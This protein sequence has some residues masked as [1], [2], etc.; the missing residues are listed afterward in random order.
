MRTGKLLLLSLLGIASAFAQGNSGSITGTI[1]D[2]AGA[3]VA[4]AAVEGKNNG[5]GSLYATVSTSTRNYTPA[6]VPPGKYEVKFTVPRFKTLKPGAP[7][8][9]APQTPR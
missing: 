4:N 7:Q 2:P 1:T 9:G 5:T 8:G 6:E 3:V